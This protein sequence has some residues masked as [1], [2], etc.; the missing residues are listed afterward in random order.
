L[1][2]RLG[3]ILKKKRI[4]AALPHI[5]GRFLDIGCGHNDLVKAYKDKGRDGLGVDVY[6]WPGADVV[7]EDTAR[8][9]YEDS[10]FDTLSIIA[11]LNHIPNRKE[12]LAEARRVLKPG[13]RLIITMI[14]PTISRIWHKLRKPWD[15]DQ[16][17]RG[18]K[19]G[20]VWG[21]T[22]AQVRQLL[23]EAG[24]AIGPQKRFMMGINYLVVG[25]SN[26]QEEK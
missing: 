5:Q 16:T 25:L 22:P 21:I 4:R 15:V 1:N 19:E 6:P 24:F 10:S 11:A 8:L 13:G 18:M 17:E 12:V 9:P 20:E 23:T 14:P 2:D 7:V 26:K 3:T